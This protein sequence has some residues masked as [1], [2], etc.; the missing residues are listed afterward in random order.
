MNL[1]STNKDHRGVNLLE[2][3]I[4][5]LSSDD[6]TELVELLSMQINVID[7]RSLNLDEDP[8]AF[9][10]NASIM[11]GNFGNQEIALKKLEMEFNAEN[12][13]NYL[14]EAFLSNDLQ[15][16]NVVKFF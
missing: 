11:F 15:H 14:K 7:L 16:K 12:I 8:S 3:S 1:V 6:Y 13:M 9:G 5:Y 4:G 2:G 10:G